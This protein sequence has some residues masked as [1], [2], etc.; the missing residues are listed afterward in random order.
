VD[1]DPDVTEYNEDEEDSEEG[2]FAS[3]TKSKDAAA[4]KK[5]FVEVE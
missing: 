1:R 3:L 5:R 4:R 2:L